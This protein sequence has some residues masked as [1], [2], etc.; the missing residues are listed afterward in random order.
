MRSLP[1]TAHGGSRP[2]IM[3]AP[4]GGPA[5]AGAAGRL[6]PWAPAFGDAGLG[7]L[8]E[9]RPPGPSRFICLSFLFRFYRRGITELYN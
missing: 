4:A 2:A 8:G 6:G 5:V 7:R 9:W 3:S 1:R